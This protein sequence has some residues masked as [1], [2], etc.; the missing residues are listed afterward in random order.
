MNVREP[1]SY[2]VADMA[3]ASIDA[4]TLAQLAGAR[5]D[6]WVAISL[7][8]NCYPALAEWITQQS[9]P[10]PAPKVAAI[11]AEMWA[12]QF[13][14]HNGR[15]ASMSEYQNALAKGEIIQEAKS[16]DDAVAQIAVG[17]KQLASGAKEFLATRVAPAAAEA[18]R[19][20][21]HTVTERAGEVQRSGGWQ[22]WAPFAIPVLAFMGFI[23]L[24]LPA[25]SASASLFGSRIS[26]KVSF[27][28]EDAEG[29]GFMLLIFMLAVLALGVIAILKN[30]KWA[31]LAAAIAGIVVGLISLIIAISLMSSVG[32]ASSS[33]GGFSVNASVGA[34]TVFLFIASVLLVAASSLTVLPKKAATQT[35][36][37]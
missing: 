19:S 33:F 13:Q 27:F 1:A 37:Q 35:P 24:F 26:H 34:G 29:V 5:E 36:V 12:A 17:A 31:K 30:V 23:S 16:T 2:T 22:M 28:D 9:V 3:D 6:L 21:Q 4:A 10:T 14:S 8:P 11:S 15:E 20:V 32:G 18:A 25:A 7:H